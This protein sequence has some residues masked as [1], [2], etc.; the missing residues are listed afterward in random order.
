MIYVQK[1]T[2][3]PS[4]EFDSPSSSEGPPRA[5]H[6]GTNHSNVEI[7]YLASRPDDAIN[8]TDTASSSKNCREIHE[9]REITALE[10]Q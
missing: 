10:Q 1:S 7:C 4:V 9:K 5:S 8:L 3:L 6:N 2:I